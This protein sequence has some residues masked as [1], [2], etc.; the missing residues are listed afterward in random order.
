MATIREEV[1]VQFIAA[2]TTG[3]G[4]PFVGYTK[5]R[6]ID[7]PVQK[8]PTLV[9]MDGPQTASHESSG[10]T[11]YTMAI[12][13]EGYVKSAN[14][15]A[16]GTDLNALYGKIVVAAVADHTLGGYAIDVREIDMDPQIEDEGSEYVGTLSVGFEID[17]Q[18][19]EN[20]P[21]TLA[22]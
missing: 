14:R 2:F 6:N 11:L 4:D 1:I 15:D 9:F 13:V 21:S 16:I 18:T 8:Y 17:F 22:P 20:D 5:D 12:V 19:L 3:V 7:A 10:V